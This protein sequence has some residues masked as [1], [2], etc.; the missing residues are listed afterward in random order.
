MWFRPNKISW[1]QYIIYFFNRHVFQKLVAF[2]TKKILQVFLNHFLL[3]PTRS[4]IS[5][6]N[7]YQSQEPWNRY[8]DD[9]DQRW[10]E[11]E[12]NRR[13]IYPSA[14]DSNI[15][16]QGGRGNSARQDESKWL[17]HARR[18]LYICAISL[19]IGTVLGCQLRRHTQLPSFPPPSPTHSALSALHLTRV[20]IKCAKNLRNNKV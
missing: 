3:S 18:W 2:S 15:V 16:C 12:K 8:Y 20:V 4:S 6:P 9:K 17:W 19:L 11:Y 13:V 10:L 1:I 14:R 5:R 7:V